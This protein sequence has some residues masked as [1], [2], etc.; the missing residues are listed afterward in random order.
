[1]QIL[2][3][4]ELYRAAIDAH[5]NNVAWDAFWRDYGPHAIAI[6]PWDRKAFH[7]LIRRLTTLVAAGDLDGTEPIDAGFNVPL[8]WELDDAAPMGGP[9]PLVPP[10]SFLA[11]YGL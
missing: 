11:G 10:P 4:Q 2:T 6:E 7:K 9:L 3:R 8:A 5:A 1:M